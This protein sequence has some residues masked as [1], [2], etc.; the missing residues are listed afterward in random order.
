MEEQLRVSI[1]RPLTRFEEYI[2]K[3]VGESLM[4]ELIPGSNRGTV[5]E[6]DMDVAI[7]RNTRY[8]ATGISSLPRKGLWMMET[9]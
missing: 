9:D 1:D 4:P 5:L 8:D 2:F 7:V 6:T 3:K